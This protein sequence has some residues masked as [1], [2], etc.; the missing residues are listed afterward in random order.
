MIENENTFFF[1][2]WTEAQCHIGD[3]EE[4]K[5]F[6]ART[7]SADLLAIAIISILK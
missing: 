5:F 3:K 6:F 2:V 4:E 1:N 7:T